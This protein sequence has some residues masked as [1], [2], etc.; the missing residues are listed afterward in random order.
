MA[1]VDAT[2]SKQ[3]VEGTAGAGKETGRAAKT[4]LEKPGAEGTRPEAA[5]AAEMQLGARGAGETKLGAAVGG[6]DAAGTSAE[7]LG[8]E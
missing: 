6:I 3:G 7:A 4:W 8:A 5:E 2:G 1:V